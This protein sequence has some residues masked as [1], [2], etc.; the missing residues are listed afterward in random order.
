MAQKEKTE[1][2]TVAT[3]NPKHSLEKLRKNCLVLFGVTVS[4]FDGA[5]HGL[6]GEYTVA[7]IKA[8]I[9]KWGKTPIKNTQKEVK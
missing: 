7:E 9:E 3:V 1:T 8:I 2:A 6:S 5:T 4:T